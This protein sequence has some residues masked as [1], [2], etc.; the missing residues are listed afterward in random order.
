MEKLPKLEKGGEN[1]RGTSPMME[2]NDSEARNM[3]ELNN[4]GDLARY[5]FHWGWGRT[6]KNSLIELILEEMKGTMKMRRGRSSPLVARPGRPTPIPGDGWR[7]T[8]ASRERPALVDGEKNDR[9]RKR[10]R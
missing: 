6:A 9:N 4:G 8:G 5:W 2:K 1:H 10:E 3:R 7:R